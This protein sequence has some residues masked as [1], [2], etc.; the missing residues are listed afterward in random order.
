MKKIKFITVLSAIVYCSFS[1]TGMDNVGSPGFHYSKLST[2]GLFNPN[3]PNST[4]QWEKLLGVYQSPI[5]PRSY[6]EINTT[7]PYMQAP[8]TFTTL[9]Y[10]FG[11]VFR[12]HSPVDAIWRMVYTN[13]NSNLDFQVGALYSSLNG[14]D[15]N[16]EAS[17]V[18]GGNMIFKTS[19]T[20][21]PSIE[22]MRIVGNV[23]G[24]QGYVGLN[25][26][27]PIFHMDMITPAFVGAELLYSGRPS[28]VS[29]SRVGFMNATVQNGR[30]IPTS[31]GT[32]DQTQAGPGYETIGNIHP[33]QDIAANNNSWAITRFVSGRGMVI[34]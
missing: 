25:N 14:A 19:T 17:R 5:I 30:F 9:G 15:F 1:Q 21:A 27:F 18:A 7:A 6:L 10:G 3:N 23:S 24:R 26:S 11:E 34:N 32:V 20:S 4:N 16:I 12:T 8:H 33:S 28:D 2:P 13:P 31:I 22:R 29:G